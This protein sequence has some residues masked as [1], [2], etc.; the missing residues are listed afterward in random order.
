MADM[1][2]AVTF[3]MLAGFCD[4]F[5]GVVARYL[6]TGKS[7]SRYGVQLDTLIDMVSFGVTPIVIVASAIGL[8]P[9]MLLVFFLYLLTAAT[10][11]AHFNTFTASD[12]STAYYQGLPVTTI[13]V[14]LPAVLLFSSD[15]LLLGTLLIMSL[16]FVLNFK[17]KKLKGAAWYLAAIAIA[18]TLILVW[19][20]I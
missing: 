4:L 7:D 13:A 18:I 2:L 20:L 19:W 6:K 17:L 1:R 16:L 8:E 10:R 14:I 12:S 15:W 3:L 5:D 11:L 9:Y